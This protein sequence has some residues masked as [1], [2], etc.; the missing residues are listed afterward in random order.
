MESVKKDREQVRGV[1]PAYIVVAGVM[2]GSFGRAVK[3]LLVELG[4]IPPEYRPKMDVA[5]SVTWGD[6]TI[7]V[8]VPLG[9]SEFRQVL[10]RL[11]RGEDL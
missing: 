4:P 5:V 10:G 7:S 1:S 8:K 11:E 6:K 2:F 9:T 3:M